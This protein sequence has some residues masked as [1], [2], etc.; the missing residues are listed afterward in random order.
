MTDPTEVETHERI[1]LEARP[2]GTGDRQWCQDKVWDD[3]IEYV[4]AD[5]IEAQAA[6]IARLRATGAAL[7]SKLDECEPHINNA[8]LIEQIRGRPYTGPQWGEDL[9]EF[10]AALAAKE[11]NNESI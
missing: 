7:V 10:R 2:T 3:G 9:K 4:R 6:E 11:T 8:F 1:W 5:L